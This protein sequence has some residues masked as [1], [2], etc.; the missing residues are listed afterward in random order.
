MSEPQPERCPATRYDFLRKA[1]LRH[2]LYAGLWRRPKDLAGRIVGL[3]SCRESSPQAPERRSFGRAQAVVCVQVPRGAP[4]GNQRCWVRV[5]ATPSQEINTGYLKY[6]I[7]GHTLTG[8]TG[9]APSPITP[10]ANDITTLEARIA[11]L[12]ALL[13]P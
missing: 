8:R 7:V 5:L 3:A 4:S 10:R 1:P 12:E 11:P 13:S 9:P 2:C 6:Q